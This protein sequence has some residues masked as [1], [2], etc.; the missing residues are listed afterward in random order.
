MR[1]SWYGWSQKAITINADNLMS[2]N[3]MPASVAQQRASDGDVDAETLRY[4]EKKTD[5][6]VQQRPRAAQLSTALARR[7]EFL[8]YVM[9]WWGNTVIV[10]MLTFNLA[11]WTQCG[12]ALY[13]FEVCELEDAV[14]LITFCYLR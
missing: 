12:F 2:L 9:T 8:A 10:V 13:V 1:N 5:R 6:D 11:E 3:F 4:E 14:S 7:Q